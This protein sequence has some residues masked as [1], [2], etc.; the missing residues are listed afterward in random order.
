MDE[1]YG[2]LAEKLL[3]VHFERL[4]VL[5]VGEEGEVGGGLAR[6]V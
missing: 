5:L 6:G 1:D 3:E 2:F 4:E